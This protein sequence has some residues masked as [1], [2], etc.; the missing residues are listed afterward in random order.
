[1]KVLSATMS[2]NNST[3]QNGSPPELTSAS[4]PL[5][6]QSRRLC[7]FR[8][9][10]KEAWLSSCFISSKRAAASVSQVLL[11]F[12]HDLLVADEVHG[13]KIIVLVVVVYLLLN[14]TQT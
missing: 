1:M 9:E 6:H 3:S 2:H 10:R 8:D 14:Y 12:H 13:D 11:L 7:E 5:P 4:C